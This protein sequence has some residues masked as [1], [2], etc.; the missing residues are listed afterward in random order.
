MKQCFKTA[1]RRPHGI[2]AEQTI[3]PTQLDQG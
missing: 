2:A 3:D 1:K